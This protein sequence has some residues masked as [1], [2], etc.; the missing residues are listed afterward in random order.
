MAMTR[1]QALQT[2]ANISLQHL[3]RIAK[4]KTAQEAALRDA[5]DRALN[6]TLNYPKEYAKQ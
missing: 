5:Q 2:S 6:A 3:G 4:A 1:T